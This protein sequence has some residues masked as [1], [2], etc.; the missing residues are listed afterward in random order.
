MSQ[1]LRVQLIVVQ[2]ENALQM[3]D[4]VMELKIAET[5]VMKLRRCARNLKIAST[6]VCMNFAVKMENALIKVLSAIITLIVATRAMSHL[7]ARVLTS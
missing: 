2:S 5:A 3:G 1:T 7:N 4:C 6:V